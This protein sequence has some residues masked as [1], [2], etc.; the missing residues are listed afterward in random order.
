MWRLEKSG[1]LSIDIVNIKR[2]E[3]KEDPAQEMKEG[4]TVE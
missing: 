4:K 3:V 1:G 2:L